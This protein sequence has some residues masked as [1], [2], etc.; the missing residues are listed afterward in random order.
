VNKLRRNRF[1]SLT[2]IL[3]LVLLW[4]VAGIP[5]ALADT[6]VFNNSAPNQHNGNEMSDFLQADMFIFGATTELNAVR[7][8]DLQGIPA[9][10]KGSLYWDIQQDAA[11]TPGAI[12]ASGTTSAVTQ[13]QTGLKDMTNT[14]S[15]YQDDFGISTISLGAGTY[16]LILHNGGFSDTNYTDF[17]WEWSQDNGKGQEYD[18]I[19]NTAW[20]SNNASHAFEL[21]DNTTSV[22][23]PSSIVLLATGIGCFLAWSRSRKRPS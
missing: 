3:A 9:D 4:H 11:G 19:A 17:Y 5:E 8:W 6:V 16:W 10:Y 23:E 1:I 20:D 22:P 7:F 18:L 21:L 14:Y 13:L 12:V 2:A 15:E